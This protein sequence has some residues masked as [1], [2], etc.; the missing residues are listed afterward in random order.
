MLG[1][2]YPETTSGSSAHPAPTIGV[3]EQER[4][5]GE[6]VRARMM[7]GTLTVP[8]SGRLSVVVQSPRPPPC[9]EAS[10]T[11]SQV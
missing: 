1:Q 9:H 4:A 3:T 5:E 11:L 10:F 2:E 6:P 8:Y 7:N